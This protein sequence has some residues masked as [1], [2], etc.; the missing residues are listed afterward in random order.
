[1]G[2]DTSMDHR[3]SGAECA[4]PAADCPAPE[5]PVNDVRDVVRT[6]L[7]PHGEFRE[8][9]KLGWNGRFLEVDLQGQD[10][11][12]GEPLGIESGSMLYLGE[13]R[14]RDGSRGSILIEHSLDRAMLAA[15]RDHWG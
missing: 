8:A 3:T 12:L 2:Y 15:D 9:L 11:A 7:L 10:F 5:A 13:L 14:Q 6:R 1:M 4:V